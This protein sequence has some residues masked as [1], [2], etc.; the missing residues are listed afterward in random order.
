[1]LENFEANEDQKKR[2]LYVAM[3]RA[4]QRLS[5]HLNGNYLDLLK[6]EDL[7]RIENNNT[8]E[9]PNQLALHLSHKD[10]YL[11]YFEFVQH[12]VNALT[13]GDLLTISAE[14]CKNEK[15]ELVLKFSMNFVDRL[16]EIMKNGFEPKEAKVNFIVHWKGED[17]EH[18]VKIILPELQFEKTNIKLR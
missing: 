5:I 18:E 15:G 16:S 12:R 2:Q 6:T 8:F 14:G 7:E 1:M 9:P 13:S 17:K 4:K 11:S 10:L 3:T